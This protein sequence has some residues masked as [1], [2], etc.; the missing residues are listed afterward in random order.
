MLLCAFADASAFDVLSLLEGLSLVGI[1]SGSLLRIQR[2]PLRIPIAQ[3]FSFTRFLR[4]SSGYGRL[5]A[6]PLLAFL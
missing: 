5:L 3:N 6:L 4:L 2:I 1:I